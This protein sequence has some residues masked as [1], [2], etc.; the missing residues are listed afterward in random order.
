MEERY[1]LAG[2]RTTRFS[3]THLPYEIAFQT[4]LMSD[5]ELMAL[6]A[7]LAK[8]SYGQYLTSLVDRSVF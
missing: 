6:A 3:E 2:Q 1:G 8:S 4:G 5:S 7:G